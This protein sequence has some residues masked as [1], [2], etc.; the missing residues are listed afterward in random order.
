MTEFD[1]ALDFLQNYVRASAEAAEQGEAI[2]DQREFHRHC[3]PLGVEVTPQRVELVR[4]MAGVVKECLVVEEAE[5][6]S[7]HVIPASSLAEGLERY[8]WRIAYLNQD[9]LE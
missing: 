9:V 6:E 1:L 3:D 2:D 8:G 4:D 5:D 7:R